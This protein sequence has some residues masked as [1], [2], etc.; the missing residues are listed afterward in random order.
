MKGMEW[1]HQH[2][3]NEARIAQMN[4]TNNFGCTALSLTLLFQN[5]LAAKFLIAHGHDL[6]NATFEP[7][8]VS[9]LTY[10]SREGM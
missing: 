5:P 4:N 8:G 3:A 9:N 2:L 1:L 10:A 7:S 6:G